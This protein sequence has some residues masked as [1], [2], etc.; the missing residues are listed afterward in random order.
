[1][2][3]TEI[4]AMLEALNVMTFDKLGLDYESFPDLTMTHDL[5]SEGLSVEQVF[6]E[7][8]ENWEAEG[9]P[10]MDVINAY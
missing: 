6:Q 9:I 7:C 4:T 8:L 5:F 3:D 2:T 10:V 1:M